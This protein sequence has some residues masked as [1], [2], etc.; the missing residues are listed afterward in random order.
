MNGYYVSNN[1]FKIVSVVVVFI[2]SCFRNEPCHSFIWFFDDLLVWCGGEDVEREQIP[3]VFGA[4]VSP[5]LAPPFPAKDAN[6][7]RRFRHRS[8]GGDRGAAV[9]II[10][11]GKRSIWALGVGDA[12]LATVSSEQLLKIPTDVNLCF[13]I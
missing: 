1:G 2:Y 8:G 11:H 3:L 12:V 7:N 5:T 6:W 13:S 4:I 10:A 9:G